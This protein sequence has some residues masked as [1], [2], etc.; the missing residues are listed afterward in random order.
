MSRLSIED[1]DFFKIES[2]NSKD[3][4]GGTYEPNLWDWETNFAFDF[5]SNGIASYSLAHISS[6]AIAI[7]PIF[8]SSDL[9]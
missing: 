9:I 3:I 4:R 6:Y 5:D 1:L 2:T 7:G 8:I